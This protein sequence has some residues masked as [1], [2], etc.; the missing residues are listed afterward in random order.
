MAAKIVAAK[1]KAKQP[2]DKFEPLWQQTLSDYVTVIAW[3][4]ETTDL[5]AASAAGEVLL[6]SLTNSS[7]ANGP[8]LFT[9]QTATDQS[10]DCLAVSSDGQF[11]AAAGQ[12]GEVKIWR[13]AELTGPEPAPMAVLQAPAWVDRMV[14][15]PQCNQLA[16]SLGKYVQVWD[17][18]TAEIVATLNFDSS[19]VLDITWHPDGDRL[20][21][22]GYQ[23]VK[24]W[25][26]SD[27]DEDPSM[28]Q[29]ASASTMI[30]WSPDGK[31]IASGNL[32]K[33]ISVVEWDNPGSPWVMRGFPGKIRQ[34]AWT[35]RPQKQNA[36]LLASASTDSIVVWE[37]HANDAIGW[38]GR[39]LGQHDDRIQAMQFQPQ[40]TTLASAGTDGW[41]VLWTKASRIGQTLTG[42]PSGFST[43]SWHPQGQ[44]LAAGG[45]AGE[46]VVWAK[47]KRGQG[48][49]QK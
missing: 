45:Q 19:S 8:T 36:P 47:T 33:T 27:W 41:L 37:R 49:G 44:Q 26:A 18:E 17:A 21:V 38:E 46:L 10:I 1:A 35:D 48:F 2:Q 31:Y 20:T 7:S 3:R 42:A 22:A 16:F 40:T 9:L 14:W 12:S 29:I 13:L 39:V 23:S 5:F 32:D 43:L 34:L 4:P 30:L 11:V 6:F 15:N 28:M 24:V 25:S